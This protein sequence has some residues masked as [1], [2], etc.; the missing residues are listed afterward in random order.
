M[1]WLVQSRLINEPFS[2][3]GL[4]VDFRFGRRAILFDLGY[5]TPLSARELFRVSDV[6][7]SHR[8]MDHFTGFDRLLRIKLHRSGVLRIV[9][10]PGMADGVEAK[11]TAYTWN[12]LDEESIDLTILVGE[13]DGGLLDNWTAFRARDNFRRQNTE[14]EPPPTG[15]VLLEDDFWVEAQMLDHGTPCLAFA[16]QETMRVNVWTEGL[17]ELGLEVGPWLS[18]AKRAARRGADDETEITATQGRTV[19]LGTLKRHA[20][21]IGPGKRL[22]Y[23]VDAAFT[24]S[25]AEKIVALAR[26]ADRLYIEAMFLQ[27]DAD[28]AAARRHLTAQQAGT[29]ARRAGVRRL[30]TLHHSPRYIDRPDSLREE[31]DRAFGEGTLEDIA[32]SAIEADD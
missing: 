20:L 3:P 10:P 19:S 27:A 31:A 24:P 1:S 23:V 28:I 14:K 29:L 18:V 30:T 26:G 8:H 17:K 32:D 12:L 2:D 6:F 25:N 15:R 7:V 5:L 13:F 9:G 4:F 11:L 16:L 22:A 21:K